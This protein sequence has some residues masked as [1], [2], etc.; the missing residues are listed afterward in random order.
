M[1]IVQLLRLIL[2]KVM[3]KKYIKLYLITCQERQFL[4]PCGR[5]D[6]ISHTILLD[7]SNRWVLEHD[8]KAG[9]HSKSGTKSI[10]HGNI[11]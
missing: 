11:S 8:I 10:K 3:E 6:N 9:Y 1:I 7:Q 4:D 5:E 2:R